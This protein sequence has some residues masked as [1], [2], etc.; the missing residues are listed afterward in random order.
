[1]SSPVALLPITED[2]LPA[3]CNLM[4]KTLADG[5]KSAERWLD[6]FT[7]SWSSDK[8]NN[9]YMLRTDGGEIVGA[10][11]CIH[12]LRPVAG[13]TLSVC[14]LTSWTVLPEY[15]GYS[16]RLLS[17]ALKQNIDVFT[18][19]TP[20]PST[21]AIFKRFKFEAVDCTARVGINL[22]GF[23]S[24]VVTDPALLLQLLSPDALQHY[25]AHESAPGVYSIG[26]KV[27]G[28]VR[29]V[30][31]TRSK[32]KGLSCATVVYCEDRQVLRDRLTAL[33]A[34]L[35][36][37]LGM[38]FLRIEER[39]GASPPVTVKTMSGIYLYLDRTGTMSERELDGL[40][41]EL[42]FLIPTV[43]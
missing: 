16:M 23:A 13:K 43:P 6:A 10:L 28:T 17:A 27:D 32:L 38:V 8:P 30:V 31:V 39:F 36:F 24:G 1:M 12:G 5:Q 2:D 22:P 19:F 26:I 20:L 7:Q 14:N 18:N 25:R 4:A 9:G 15:R 29:L 3:T 42:T 41:S 35:L 37:K 21:V 11:G 34:F 40:Y 33:S